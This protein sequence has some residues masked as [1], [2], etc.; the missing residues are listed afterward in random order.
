[1]KLTLDRIV[2]ASMA[3]FAETGYHGLSM[4]RVADRLGVHAGSLYYH[5]KDKDALLRLM[6]DQVAQ[7][8][9]DAGTEALA[10]LAEDAPWPDRVHAQAAA[11]RQTIRSHPGGAALLASSPQTLS[12]GALG[13][14]ERL[15]GTLKQAGVPAADRII[16]ADTVLSHITGFVLQE[17]TEP[18]ALDGVSPQDLAALAERFPLTFAEAPAGEQDA[19]FTASID[20]LCAAIESAI[21]S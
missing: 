19:K 16:A 12:P 15:L 10:G 8:A 7:Q 9:F 20:L 13:L 3:V 1:M 18:V 6:A 17:Q 4:R 11:L 5:V 14:M 2:A 21:R